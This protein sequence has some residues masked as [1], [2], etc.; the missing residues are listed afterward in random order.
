MSHF[1]GRVRRMR[2]GAK[3]FCHGAVRALLWVAIAW[4]SAI[5]CAG[6]LD[7]PA[8]QRTMAPSLGVTRVTLYQNG[9]GYFE[10][11]GKV[12]GDLLTLRCRPSQINDLLKSLTVIDRGS[13]RALSVSLPL[14]KTSSRALAELPRQVRRASGLLDVLKVFRG[15][16]VRLEGAIGSRS[17][18]VLGVE[19][20]LISS[21]GGEGDK[22]LMGWRVTLKRDRGDLVVYPI[23]AVERLVMLDRALEVGLEKSLDVSLA[24]G[25]WKPITLSVRLSDRSTHDLLVSYV[26]EMPNWKPAY[27]LVLPEGRKP[28]LQ[29]WAVVDNVSGEAWKQVRLSLVAGR[30]MSFVYDLHRPRFT[31]RVDLTPRSREVA[32]A[33][34]R[35]SP[36]DAA[37][38]APKPS[39]APM[40]K[41][42]ES[43]R[44]R[45]PARPR[46]RRGRKKMKLSSRRLAWG[47]G[48]GGGG[49]AAFNRLLEKKVRSRVSGKQLGG[50][51]RYDLQ[52]AVTVPDNSSTLVNIVNARVDGDQV[53]L[54]RPEDGGYNGATP[55]RAVRFANGTGFALEKGPVAIYAKG[56]F[57]GEGFLERMEKAQTA[58]LTFAVDGNVSMRHSQGF[59]YKPIRL[60]K[61]QHGKI[62]SEVLNIRRGS[63]TIKN[64]HARAIVAYIKS[65]KPGGYKLQDAPPKT[66]HASDAA[67]VPVA[68]PAGAEKTLVVKWVSSVHRYLAVDSALAT[69]VLKLYLGTAEVPAAIRSE[70]NKIL[71]AKG[72]ID[73]I[74][75]ERQRQARLRDTLS[76]EQERVREN[77]RL[78]RKVRGQAALKNK[79]AASLASLEGRLGKITAQYVKLDEQQ[80][81]LQREMR[82]LIAAIS[83]TKNSSTKSR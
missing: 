74:A 41:S 32:L 69:S 46:A 36:G 75:I 65:K 53:V 44:Y 20:G 10:R 13:G 31:R 7:A 77:L 73:E 34:T 48:R 33:P 59:E 38:E 24:E 57:V 16:R 30:P 78:M 47:A 62:V 80:A 67:Y 52:D 22:P 45:R 68:I 12:R 28:L 18:R 79:L 60:L 2:L 15:A 71:K 23:A 1:D 6:A 61:I 56:T 5:G 49:A 50:L 82:A 64:R 25:S 76:E 83:L 70:L 19:Q 58:F 27:R 55:Y 11:E 40:S 37:D 43:S 66:V 26:V 35:E 14:D 17:G 29:G 51:F 3:G 54:F 72:R 9:V 21:R 81:V 63:F 42:A 4:G 8:T 39:L